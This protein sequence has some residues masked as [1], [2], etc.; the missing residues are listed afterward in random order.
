MIDLLVIGD[1]QYDTIMVLDPDEVDI[2]CQL[3]THDCVMSLDYAGKVLV[4]QMY[5]MVAGNAANAT[6]SGVRLHGKTAFWSLLGDDDTAKR[7][8]Q[9]FQSEHVH[10]QWLQTMPGAASNNSTVI[11]VK[12]ER[13]ILVYHAPRDYELP[14]NLPA[15]QW[16]YLT[17]MA[18]GS[19]S[20]FPEL[21]DFIQRTGAKLAYQPGTFQL[22]IGHAQA[23]ELLAQ[24]ALIV[25]NKEEAQAYSE[26]TELQD[27]TALCEALRALGP[28][29][30]LVTD[31]TNGA[32]VSDGTQVWQMGIRPEIA[33][34]E[35]TGAG[36]AYSSAFTVALME[37]RPLNEALRWAA[38][39]AESVIGQFGPQAGILTREQ[40]ETQLMQNPEFQPVRLR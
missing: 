40:L 27:L 35:S 15:V 9:Y 25:M 21:A 3:N 19:E 23:R 7:Q 6:V 24:A 2:Q 33:R 26:L 11:S 28:D 17:S 39:N 36:D 12:G 5:Q 13:T 22:R 14:T 4:S 38:L 16:V 37:G 20:M 32:V 18:H 34:V 8:I 29:I 1:T 10:T 30:A 31:G